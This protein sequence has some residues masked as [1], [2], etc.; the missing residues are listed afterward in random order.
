M[1][2][3][4]RTVSCCTFLHACVIERHGMFEGLLLQYWLDWVRCSHVAFYLQ[5]LMIV[6]VCT[7]LA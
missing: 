1:Y 7:L 5:G 2:K 4:L 6:L 3:V